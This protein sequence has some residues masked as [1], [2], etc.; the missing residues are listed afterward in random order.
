MIT[1]K[2]MFCSVAGVIIS[3]VPKEYSSDLLF[4]SAEE[5]GITKEEAKVILTELKETLG[6]AC[7]KLLKKMQGE[8]TTTFGV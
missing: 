1:N 3:T 4:Q 2:E 7:A 5:F 8:D 6:F